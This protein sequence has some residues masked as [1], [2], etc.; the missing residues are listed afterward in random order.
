MGK[1]VGIKFKYLNLEFSND[2]LIAEPY[3]IKKDKQ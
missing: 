1:D 3:K 2:D